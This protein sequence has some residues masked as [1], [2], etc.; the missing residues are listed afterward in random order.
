ML[1]AGDLGFAH[2]A[3][4]LG[5]SN[6]LFVGK[7]KAILRMGTWGPARSVGSA[8]SAVVGEVVEVSPRMGAW[9][10]VRSV[11]S[12]VSVVVG[13]GVEVSSRRAADEDKVRVAVVDRVR[14]KRPRAM[15]AAPSWRSMTLSPGSGAW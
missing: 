7:S 4:P 2:P 8:L 1:C 5:F 14:A 10:S 15:G 11:G 9:G 12:A 13:A 3:A 6:R